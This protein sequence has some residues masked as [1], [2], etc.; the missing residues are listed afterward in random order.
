MERLPI[1]YFDTHAH[2]DIMSAYTNDIDT[3]VRQMISQSMPQL[4]SSVVT[5][6]SIVVS[7]II[8]N[9]PLLIVTLFMVTTTMT[10]SV[11][12]IKNAGRFFVQQQT[13]LGK[14]NGYIEEMV[15]RPEGRQGLLPRRRRTLEEFQRA[16]TRPCARAGV[17]AQSRIAATMVPL[18][19]VAMGYLSYALRRGRRRLCWRSTGWQTSG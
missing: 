2:G 12:R 8:L 19:V 9:V 11:K 10:L 5:I 18:T 6:V 3:I 17:Q 16:A 4:I 14:V 13:D 15:G 1:K 7:M